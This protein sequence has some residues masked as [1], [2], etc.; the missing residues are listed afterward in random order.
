MAGEDGDFAQK[1]RVIE[2]FDA[3]LPRL[4]A[5]GPEVLCITGDHSTPVAMKGHSWHPIP[6]LV[7][8]RHAFADGFDRFHEKHCR[9]GA[10]GT[11]ASRD[12][13]AVLLAHAGRLD[14]YGA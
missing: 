6:V 13:I 9:A 8:A 10:L 5:R 7:H 11:F 12:L 3:A 14:K 2:Q 1:V 4:L